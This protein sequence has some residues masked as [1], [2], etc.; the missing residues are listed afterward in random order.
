MIK[1]L[2]PLAKTLFAVFV[3]AVFAG[4]MYYSWSALG[5]IFPGDLTGQLFGM[6]LFDLAA[7][8]WFLVFVKESHSTM[9]YVFALVGFMVGLIGTLGLVSIEVGLS[10]GAKLLDGTTEQLST[11]FI[12]A[13][14]SHLVLTYA[15][16]AAAP[17]VSAGISLGVERARITDRAQKDA[18]RMLVENTDQLSLPIAREHVRNVMRDLNLRSDESGVIDLQATD[19]SQDDQEKGVGG[20]QSFFRS[21]LSGWGS[22][23]RKF[24]SSVASVETTSQQQTPMQSPAQENVG[25]EDGDG[26]A[27][28]S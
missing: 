7:L 15:Y 5:L 25:H 4:V 9:Q 8:V 18:E 22:G 16:H 1:L 11:I 13:M 2:G 20:T 19:V 27:L 14:V 21:I 12:I 26:S 23:A 28:K 17:D 3:L 10:S 24:E 6:A